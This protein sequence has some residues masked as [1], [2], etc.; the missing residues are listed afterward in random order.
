M[1]GFAHADPAGLCHGGPSVGELW[2]LPTA[3]TLDIDGTI[4]T[5]HGHQ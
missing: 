1:L 4:D 2:H 3:I 5:V